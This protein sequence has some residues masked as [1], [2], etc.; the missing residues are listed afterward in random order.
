MSG[1]DIECA[2]V[3]HPGTLSDA[4]ALAYK[5]LEVQGRIVIQHVEVGR[6]SERV[7]VKYLA[8]IP[9]E[10]VRELLGRA[11]REIQETSEKGV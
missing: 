3:W 9:H 2:D 4:A 5:L 10:W 7:T 11:K 6:Y 1:P 8:D